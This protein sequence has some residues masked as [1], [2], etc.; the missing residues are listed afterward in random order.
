MHYRQDLDISNNNLKDIDIDQLPE[1]ISSLVLSEI[2]KKIADL[3]KFEQIDVNEHIEDN[4]TV[5]QHE[6][7]FMSGRQN[8]LYVYDILNTLNEELN[9]VDVDIESCKILLQELINQ[10]ITKP[11]N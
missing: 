7:L 11:E 2:F 6:I 10:F 3:F 1:V 8:I 5:F 9:K 4:V